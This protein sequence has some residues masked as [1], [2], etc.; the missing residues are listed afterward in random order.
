LQA[1]SVGQ[2][3][4]EIAESAEENNMREMVGLLQQARAELEAFP[5]RCRTGCQKSPCFACARALELA[6]KLKRAEVK[7][8][9]M[10]VAL[11]PWPPTQTSHSAL[12]LALDVP[13]DTTLES[14]AVMMRGKCDI[15]G[16]EGYGIRGN[17]NII[18]G[19]K[20]CD[21]CHAAMER[22]QGRL[23]PDPTDAGH[24]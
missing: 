3:G 9:A 17:E 22:S 14:D 20:V 15:V 5:A 6:R 11:Q 23:A 2:E 13:V 4:S 1:V 19:K 7:A 12:R 16:C 24:E 21:Y 18:N 10:R 8:A